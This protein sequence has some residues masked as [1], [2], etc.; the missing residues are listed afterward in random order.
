MQMPTASVN[1]IS[2]FFLSHI[3]HS[4]YYLISETRN[5]E[6]RPFPFGYDDKL[7]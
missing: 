7:I 2:I 1:A 4:F 5:G 3:L 6:N